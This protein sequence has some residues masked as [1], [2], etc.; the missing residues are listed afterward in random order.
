M[1][2]DERVYQS[3]SWFEEVLWLS[4]GFPADDTLLNSIDGQEVGISMF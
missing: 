1:V 4:T 2:D 3:E